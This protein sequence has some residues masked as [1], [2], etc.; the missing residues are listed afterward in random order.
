[1]AKGKKK[2]V[3]SVGIEEVEYKGN[4]ILKIPLSSDGKY[5]FSFGV[6][7]A[8]AILKNVKAIK[9]FYLKHK[10]GKDGK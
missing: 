9:A 5:Y 2:S 1:M 4:P 6:K 8:Y 10:D 7:K 3:D